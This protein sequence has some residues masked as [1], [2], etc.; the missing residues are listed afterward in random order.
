MP[1][2]LVAAPALSRSEDAAPSCGYRPK[3]GVVAVRR[4]VC[5]WACGRQ[6]PTLMDLCDCHAACATC[7][8]SL[9]RNTEATPGGFGKAVESGTVAGVSRPAFLN[10]RRTGCDGHL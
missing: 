6:L 3:G 9:K 5:C 10:S 7:C 1:G 4:K 8:V 2:R